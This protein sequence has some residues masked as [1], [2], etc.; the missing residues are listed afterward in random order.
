[1][2]S[3]LLQRFLA[4]KLKTRQRCVPAFPRFHEDLEPRLVATV[5][6]QWNPSGII[7]VNFV[8]TTSTLVDAFGYY[9]SL[10]NMGTTSVTQNV[11]VHMIV[12]QDGVLGNGDDLKIGDYDFEYNATPNGG[13]ASSSFA[14]AYVFPSI[15]QTIDVSIYR[16]SFLVIDP[17]HLIAESDETN[18]VR[19]QPIPIPPRIILSAEESLTQ[20]TGM[21]VATEATYNPGD[22]T[23]TTG[24]ILSMGYDPDQV[25]RAYVATG[26]GIS[27]KGR[28]VRGWIRDGK[29]KI[30]KITGGYASRID[31]EFTRDV[32][33]ATVQRVIRNLA[34]DISP[35]S[36]G[37]IHCDV[38][39]QDNRFAIGI[40]PAQNKTVHLT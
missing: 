5:D 14:D 22:Q 24:M 9:E 16:T 18:N 10:K 30:A 35:G 8:D 27:Q 28:G 34:M 3:G 1:M 36:T 40:H 37:D 29:Q 26:N 23:G 15:G 13:L 11:S 19:S 6:L 38:Y 7:N 32:S 33:P 2:F 39:A 4:R 12:S 31:I 25:N 17:N 21:L 20:K